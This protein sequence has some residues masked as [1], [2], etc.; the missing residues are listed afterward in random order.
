[1]NGQEQGV[2][3]IPKEAVRSAENCKASP[4]C[5]LHVAFEV[6]ETAQPDCNDRDRIL[7]SVCNVL[8]SRVPF[9]ALLVESPKTLQYKSLS[10]DIR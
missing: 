7:A 8:H 6:A 1:M 5:F 2:P 4:P 9:L 3:Y 10:A